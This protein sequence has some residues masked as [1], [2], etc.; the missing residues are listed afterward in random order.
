[1]PSDRLTPPPPPQAFSDHSDVVSHRMGFIS[2]PLAALTARILL[3]SVRLS[4]AASW[5]V[6]AA[7]YLALTTFRVL[8]TI[9]ILGKVGPGLQEQGRVSP[10]TGLP[11]TSESTSLMLG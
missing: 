10:G 1:M 11:A 5:L 7:A 6:L 8:N 9:V 3:Q 4:G 2:L